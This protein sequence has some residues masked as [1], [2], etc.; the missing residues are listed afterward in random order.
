MLDDLEVTLVAG[1]DLN[2]SAGA[3]V[4]PNDGLVATASALADEVSARVLPRRVAHTF[5]DA[6]SVFFGDLLGLPWARALTWDPA[7]LQVV[8]AAIERQ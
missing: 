7:V 2:W 1:D 5:P 6:H 8:I 3:S 4:S